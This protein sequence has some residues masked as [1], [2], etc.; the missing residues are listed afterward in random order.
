MAGDTEQPADISWGKLA[1][2]RPLALAGV[3]LGVSVAAAFLVTPGLS[4]QRVPELGE[5]DI[6]RPFRAS[7]VAGFKA[8][9][10]F[11]VADDRKTQRSRSG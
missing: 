11:E 3:L 5:E 7:S 6:G 1:V 8:S 4:G 9:R 2:P 10:D